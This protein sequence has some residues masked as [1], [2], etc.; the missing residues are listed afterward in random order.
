M[1]IEQGQSEGIAA[2]DSFVMTRLEARPGQG[3]ILPKQFD[4]CLGQVVPTQDEV[5]T[6]DS[7]RT[8]TLLIT[9]PT[10]GLRG[11]I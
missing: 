1:N 2:R 6:P 9:C 3:T 11:M 8:R 7:Y 10:C 4:A 5:R